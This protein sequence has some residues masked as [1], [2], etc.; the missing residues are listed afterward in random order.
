MAARL[1][2]NR[3]EGGEAPAQ[4]GGGPDLRRRLGPVEATALVTGGVI[5]TSVFVI[6]SAVAAAAGSP[7]LALAVWFIAGLLAAVSALCL[8]EL[9]AAIPRTGGIYAFLKQAYPSELVAFSYGWMMSTVYGPGA[10]AVVATMSATFIG[11]YLRTALGLAHEP[12]RATALAL[13]AAASIVNIVGV[14]AGGFVQAVLTSAKVLLLTLLIVVPLLVMDPDMGRIAVRS[15]GEGAV[16]IAGVTG[17]LMLCTFSFSGAHFLTL[18]G[19]EVRRPERTIPLAITLGMGAVLALYLLF[20][21]V[22]FATLPFTVVATS[23]RIAFD[24]MGAAL[25]PA[26]A[27]IAAATVFTS[28][29]AVLNAQCLGYPRILYSLSRDGLLFSEAAVVDRRTGAPVVA[30]VACT[31]CAAM[32]VF[33]GTYADILG[34]VGFVSQ[35][36]MLL[37]VLS[38][39]LLRRRMSDMPR[40]YR[41]WGYPWTPLAYLAVMASY[42]VSLL[43]TKTGQVAVGLFVVAAGL[44]VYAVFRRRIRATPVV[45]GQP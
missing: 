11:P 41:V 1:T 13:L 26:G 28:G 29:V 35:F 25:G 19:G 33:S 30:I 12:V 42:L 5:G 18:V 16:T 4:D 15:E 3:N 10:M 34:Y 2:H 45:G 24:L 6:P 38:V 21:V 14:R 39:I 27:A 36:F 7:G 23:E 31:L 17:A 9:S 8:A 20:N 37:M 32:Y 22:I 43:V 40:P 44:P